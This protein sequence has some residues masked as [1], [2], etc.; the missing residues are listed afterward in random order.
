MQGAALKAASEG[1]G[2]SG[3]PRW[4]GVG[5]GVG[6]GWGRRWGR[7]WGGVGGGGGGGVG[8]G[9]A[10]TFKTETKLST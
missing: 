1:G 3:S 10:L 2:G 8:Q 6:F 4:P 9:G 5:S 7:R